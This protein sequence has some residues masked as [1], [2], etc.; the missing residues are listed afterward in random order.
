MGLVI[1][2]QVVSG[3]SYMADASWL[4]KTWDRLETNAAK[5][6][7]DWPKAEQYT[8]YAGGQIVG[9]TLP[10]EDMMILGVSLGNTFDSVKASQDSPQKRLVEDLLMVVLHLGTLK[11]MA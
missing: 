5:Q 11:W 8:H 4:S 3:Y 1:G 10:E 6:S 9:D 2:M 7:N